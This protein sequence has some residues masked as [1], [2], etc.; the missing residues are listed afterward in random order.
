L[1]SVIIVKR[2]VPQKICVIERTQTG[3]AY[4]GTRPS[5]KSIRSQIESIHRKTDRKRCGLDAETVV[6]ELN[7]GLRGWANYF[8]L[9]PVSKIY[10]AID[11]HATQRLRRWLC[12]K[13]KVGGSGYTRYPDEFL[14]NKL[15]LVRL[16]QLTPNLPWAKA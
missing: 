1:A 10:R 3:R 15:G 16:R 8:K 6:K 4:L 14:Y 11:T 5:K 2:A 9:G 12:R 13:H 7:D